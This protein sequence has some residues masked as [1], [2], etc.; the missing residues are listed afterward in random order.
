MSFGYGMRYLLGIQVEVVNK[1]LSMCIWNLCTLLREKS[2]VC[3]A[4]KFHRFEPNHE[5]SAQYCFPC[6]KGSF[7]NIKL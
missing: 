2:V 1:Q 7:K 3:T 6:V 5:A 4:Y